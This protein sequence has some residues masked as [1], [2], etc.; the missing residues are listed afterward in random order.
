MRRSTPHRVTS[1]ALDKK[2]REEGARGPKCAERDGTASQP[3]V[4]SALIW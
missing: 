2:I 1:L 4:L 3:M